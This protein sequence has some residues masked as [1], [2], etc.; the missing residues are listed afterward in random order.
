MKRP[1]GL[2]K[3]GRRWGREGGMKKP[4]GVGKVERIDQM[5]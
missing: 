3:V 1:G 4:D 5:G 2:G